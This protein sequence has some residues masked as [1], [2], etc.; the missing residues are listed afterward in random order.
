MKGE[1]WN[2]HGAEVGLNY[3]C[4]SLNDSNRPHPQQ[5]KCLNSDTASGMQPDIVAR[6][7][8]HACPWQ[9][10]YADI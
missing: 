6:T 3:S 4:T 10:N 1:K 7:V 5:N 8:I 9:Y 2:Q